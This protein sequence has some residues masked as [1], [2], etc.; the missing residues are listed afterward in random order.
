MHQPFKTSTP[1]GLGLCG[2]IVG[3]NCHVLTSTAIPL[4]SSNFDSTHKLAVIIMH[5][6]AGI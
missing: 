5:L 4:N 2:H 6:P 3:L 1:M